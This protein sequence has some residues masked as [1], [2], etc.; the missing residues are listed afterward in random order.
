[1]E[2]HISQIGFEKKDVIY[3]AYSK[4]LFFAK[5]IISLEVL[6]QD[7]V[8]INPFMNFDYFLSQQD[9]QTK[10][11]IR[12]ANNSLVLKADK[13]WVIGEISDGVLAEIQLAN[14]NNIP[15]T[16]FN[17]KNNT[18]KEISKENVVF[19]LGC[20]QKKELL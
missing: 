20:E 14:Q 10:Q 8:P 15:I 5:S 4:K 19:E 2:K 3:T 1:M 18:L 7:K 9:E 13:I 16:Y 17:L 6:K 12:H 11:V